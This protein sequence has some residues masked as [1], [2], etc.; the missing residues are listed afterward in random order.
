ME[1]ARGVWVHDLDPVL[2]ELPGALAIRWYGLAYLGGFLLAWLLVRQVLR[3][4]R[5]PFDE[6][7]AGN[8]VVTLAI[9]AV[10]GARVG[11][12]V[13][14]VPSLLWTV[15]RDFPFWR[16][17]ALHQGG[18]ASHGGMAGALVAAALFAWRRGAPFLHAADL[19]A[20][21]APA[22]L[23]LGRLAN[24]INGELY[25]RPSSDSLPWAV[26]FPQ[27]LWALGP[28]QRT[29]ALDA[30]GQHLREPAT[31]HAVIA[32][33]QSGHGEVAAAVA[34]YLSPRHPSQLYEALLEG[35]LLLALLAF[36]WVR[37]RRP[38]TIA[39]LFAVGYGVVRVLAEQFREPDAHIA[40]L[41]Y[42]A[43]Q[44]TRGQ[45]LSLVLVVAG[46]IVLALAHKQARPPLGGWRTSGASHE[47]A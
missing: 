11:Y 8:L 30:A 37:P 29:S 20:F 7:E 41:E 32:A 34:P 1:E 6:K 23:F 4:G 35:A 33:I 9:G 18:M 45:W 25:G 22:G 15:E 27:E 12:A 47:G 39:G 43:L 3:G 17:L 13:L 40:H 46:G 36:V 31:V 21:G 28:A 26:R 44:V 5:S 24:F 16:L 2:M 10:V 42:A 38:G 19:A 14:Y